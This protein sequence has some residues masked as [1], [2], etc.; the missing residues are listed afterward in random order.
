MTVLTYAVT[1]A[2]P[3]AVEHGAR[4]ANRHRAAITE[5]L[6]KARHWAACGFVSSGHHVAPPEL[7]KELRDARRL[8]RKEATA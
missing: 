6:K 1:G 4:Y 2:G 3:L 5:R 8:A 7:Q